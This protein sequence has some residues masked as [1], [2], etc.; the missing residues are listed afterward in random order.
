PEKPNWRRDDGLRRR[1]GN[2][3]TITICAVIDDGLPFAHR[4]FRDVTGTRTRV[5]FCW[6]QSGE[7]DERQKSVLFGREYTRGQIEDYIKRFGDDED[8]LYREA[9][10]TIDT[11]G[12]TSLIARHATHGAHVMDL[13]TGYALERGEV[14]VEEIR[15]IAVQLPNTIAWDTSGFGKD[16]YMLSAFHYIF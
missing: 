9:R 3:K 2:S 8:A 11:E 7:R 16:M 5:E 10:A 1:I 4:N 13:A 14:P 12:L 6:L 15:I